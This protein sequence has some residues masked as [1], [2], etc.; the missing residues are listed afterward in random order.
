MT[1]F[2]GQI[3][4]DTCHSIIAA[5]A[6]LS[7]TEGIRWRV[8]PSTHPA[9]LSALSHRL[10]TCQINGDTFELPESLRD[11]LPVRFDIADATY[12]LAIIYLWMLSNIER[13]SRTPER[14]DATNALLWYLN[15]TTPHLRA[16]ELRK[17][18][19]A[20]DSTTRLDVET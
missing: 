12:P 14:P 8:T 17:L 3:S 18:R 19:R 16:G 1:P 9:P 5:G 10:R 4:R 20:L 7:L 13:G 6:N 2:R 11:W 15:V